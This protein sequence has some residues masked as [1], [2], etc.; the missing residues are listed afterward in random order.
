MSK[1]KSIIGS[2]LVIMSLS[3]FVVPFVARPVMAA[4]TSCNSGF[5]GFPAWYRNLT[6]DP[7]CALKS[8]DE[9]GGLGKFIWIIGLN[10]IELVLVA[11]AYIASG[12]ILYG[13][14][15]FMISR[16]KPEGAARARQ[17]ILDAVVGLIIAFSALA[18]VQFA[19]NG[20]I[21]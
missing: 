18:I 3:T 21:K 1:F 7:D 16:G 19:I 4:G 11:I 12:F 13:G 15:L 6:K 5:L 14:F 2:L 8:P 9:V 10:V 17:T 20:V